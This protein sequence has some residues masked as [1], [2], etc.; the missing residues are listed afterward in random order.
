LFKRIIVP[1]DLAHIDLLAKSLDVAASISKQFGAEVVY[2]GVTTS[3]PSDV[4]HNPE[5]FSKKLEEFGRDQAS[6]HGHDVTVQAIQANDP[7]S[8]LDDAILKSISAL[9]ADLVI[10]ASHVPTVADYIWPSNGGKIASHA[11]ISVFL[12]R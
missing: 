6:R 12:V 3:A 2:V 1:V 4:A 9:G 5:E 11:G 7:A 8:E 10:M